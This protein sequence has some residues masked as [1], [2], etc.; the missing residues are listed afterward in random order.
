M[1]SLKVNQAR[2]M[3]SE[4]TMLAA[5]FLMNFNCAS[6]RNTSLTHNVKQN[7]LTITPDSRAIA[8]VTVNIRR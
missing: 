8:K 3:N 4:A 6:S 7:T 1:L 5:G 2:D